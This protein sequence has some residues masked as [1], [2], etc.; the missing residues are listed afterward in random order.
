MAVFGRAGSVS[1]TSDNNAIQV[2]GIYEFLRDASKADKRFDAEARIAA[3][4]VAENLLNKAKTEAGSITRNRQATEVMKGMKVGKDR[5]P[6][7]Y[8]ASTSAFVSTTNPNRNRKRKVTRGD[9]FFGAEFGGGKFGKGMKTSAGA[10]SVNKKGESRDGYRKGG[11]HT[12]QFLRHRGKAGY[13]FWPT[14]R[15][16]K[17]NIAKEYLDAIQKVINTLKDSA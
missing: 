16:Q 2:K 6:T 15:K 9:V 12:S 13:F 1:I 17:D 10:R 8:L 5:I 7:L 11:G 3:G 14:V 4:K